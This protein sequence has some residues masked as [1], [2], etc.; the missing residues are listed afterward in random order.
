MLSDHDSI[1]TGAS[2]WLRVWFWARKIRYEGFRAASKNKS[3]PQIPMDKEEKAANEKDKKLKQD[4]LPCYDVSRLRKP[5][6]GGKRLNGGEENK[7]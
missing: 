5:N 3:P 6:I 4:K 2:E 7:R 1:A